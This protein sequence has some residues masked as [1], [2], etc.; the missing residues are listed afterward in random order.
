MQNVDRTFQITRADK[1]LLVKHEYDVQVAGFISWL[2][3]YTIYV[4]V[5]SNWQLNL[6][7]FQAWCMLVNDKVLFRMQWP[8]FADLQVNGM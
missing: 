7:C 4:Y 8:Q 2:D 6:F 3:I 1:D 5:F